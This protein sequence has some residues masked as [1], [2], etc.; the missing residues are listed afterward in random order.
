MWRTWNHLLVPPQTLGSSAWRSERVGDSGQSQTEARQGSPGGHCP[1]LGRA[2]MLWLPPGS[3][4]GYSR[5]RQGGA[6][7]R[8]GL[9]IGIS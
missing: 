8:G 5:A 6:V 7:V 4:E 1:L 9:R 2:P 3:N